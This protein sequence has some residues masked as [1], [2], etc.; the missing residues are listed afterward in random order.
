VKETIMTNPKQHP[1]LIRGTSLRGPVFALALICVLTMVAMPRAQAQ[2][3]TVLH[4]FTGASDGAI[5]YGGLTL[6]QAGNIYGTASAGGFT[7]NNCTAAGCGTVFKLTHR[8]S[9]WTF[10]PLYIFQ[11]NTDGVA[12]YAGVTIG[13]NGT[14]YGT[15]LLGGYGTGTLFNLSPPAHATGNVLGGWTE[16]VLYLFDNGASYPVYGKVIFDS[17]GNI[18]GTTYEGGLECTDGGNCGTVFKL[19]PSSGGWSKTGYAFPGGSSGGN[20]LSGV[21]MDGSR[22][23]YGTTSA[24][25]VTP[26]AYELI[27]SASGWTEIVLHTFGYFDDPRGGVIF[28]GTGGL[29]GTTVNGAVYQLSPSGGQWT[30]NLL[31]NFSGPSGPWSDVVRDA[32]GNLYGTTC[33]DGRFSHGSVFKLTP[34]QG[35]WTETDLYDFTGGSDGSCPVGAVAINAAGDVYGTTAAGG[36]GCSGNGGCGVVWQIT[37]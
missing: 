5:P 9:G 2:T 14:L 11:G 36:S 24:A 20:P 35:G 8:G 18:Y 25:S 33:A 22:N 34:S 32:S 6:D 13:P 10:A 15:T 4:P 3:F 37:P 17:A 16:T 31:Y 28:D 19:T 27:P 1:T 21:V 7:G 12:P 26:V 23:L 29:F 30:Y